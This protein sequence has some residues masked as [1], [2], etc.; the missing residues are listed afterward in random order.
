MEK[1]Y[2]TGELCINTFDLFRKLEEKP[3]GRADKHEYASTHFAGEKSK[4]LTVKIIP[5]DKHLQPTTVSG[6]KDFQA[7]TL[8]FGN[9]KEFS[10][11]YSMCA[12]NPIGIKETKELI[13]VKNFAPDKDYVVLIHNGTEFL[14]RL[15]SKL[16]KLERECKYALIDYVD[17]KSYTGPMGPFRKFDDFSYQKELRF[18][19]LFENL[20]QKFIHI[21]SIED[22]AYPPMNEKEFYSYKIK[23][24]LK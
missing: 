14:K 21:G 20:E 24:L 4:Y 15:D 8:D 10:H 23:E 16:K 6:S 13:D 11:L 1:F 22:I 7:L 19:F 17:K 5:H 12:V 9:D 3:D 18:A 2:K